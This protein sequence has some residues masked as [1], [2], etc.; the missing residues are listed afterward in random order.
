MTNNAWQ[1]P[2]YRE[3]RSLQGSVNGCTRCGS[4]V[5]DVIAHNRHHRAL[6]QLR[7]GLVSV[8]QLIVPG[9]PKNTL[10]SSLEL[11]NDVDWSAF[12]DSFNAPRKMSDDQAKLNVRMNV[13]SG[14]D[15]SLRGI[16]RW[17][18][19]RRMSKFR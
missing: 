12:L 10:L 6:D 3:I 11:A 9:L 5:F 18:S 2:E 19:R 17:R 16:R 15:S 4:I 14:T 8:T 13:G 7:N 1:P